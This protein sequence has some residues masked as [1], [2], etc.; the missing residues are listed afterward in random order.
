[1]LHDVSFSVKPGTTTAL[2]G[3]SGIGKTTII[4]LKEMLR[5]HGAALE[6]AE[7]VVT[8]LK[9]I[10]GNVA[11]VDGRAVRNVQPADDR[12]SDRGSFWRSS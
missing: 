5:K 2:V 11:L 12:P 9:S 1:M 8:R 10:D 7:K 6:D 3:P 4:S